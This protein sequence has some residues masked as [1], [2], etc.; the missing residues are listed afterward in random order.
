M[1]SFMSVSPEMENDTYNNKIG[2]HLRLL[3]IYA[4]ITN[5]NKKQQL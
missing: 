1:I 2:Q 3:L 5:Y 4:K